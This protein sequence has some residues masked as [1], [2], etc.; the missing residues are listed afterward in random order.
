M[1]A[2]AQWTRRH[3]LWDGP[4]LSLLVEGTAHV[5]S[6]GRMSLGTAGSEEG[7]AGEEGTTK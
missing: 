4:D 2:Q 1:C 6:Q 7:A 3:P 5:R